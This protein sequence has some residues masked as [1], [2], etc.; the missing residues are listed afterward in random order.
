MLKYI[1]P[2]NFNPFLNFKDSI[3]LRIQLNFSFAPFS[4]PFVAAKQFEKKA[5]S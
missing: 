4:C 5:I 3:F 2:Y 1:F